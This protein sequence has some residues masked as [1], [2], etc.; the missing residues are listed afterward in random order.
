MEIVNTQTFETQAGLTG[1]RY[2]LKNK[3]KVS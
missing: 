2:T 1:T 3:A